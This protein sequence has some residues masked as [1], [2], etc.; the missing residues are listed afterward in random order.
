MTKKLK[1][2]INRIADISGIDA[3]RTTDGT[4]HDSVRHARLV[5]RNLDY[6][7][8]IGLLCNIEGLINP[9]RLTVND[10]LRRHGFDLITIL[11]ARYDES[12]TEE[13]NEQ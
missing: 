9:Q 8:S 2:P 13:T 3:Y 7:Y 12:A 1:F 5:Q 6:D 10:F 4:I 11:K